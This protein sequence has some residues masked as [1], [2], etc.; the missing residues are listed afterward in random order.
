VATEADGRV[1]IDAGIAVEALGGLSNEIASVLAKEFEKAMGRAGIDKALIKAI[2]Q[3]LSSRANP[4]LR[5]VVRNFSE[6]LVKE[7]GKAGTQMGE[8]LGDKAILAA[9]TRLTKGQVEL[10]R[11]VNQAISIVEKEATKRT[12][13]T[14]QATIKRAEIEAPA[15]LASA[16]AKATEATAKLKTA[17][18]QLRLS[19]DKTE[20]E[21]KRVEQRRISLART[22]STIPVR[23]EEVAGRSAVNSLINERTQQEIA[24]RTAIENA[25]RQRQLDVAS[26]QQDE[27]RRTLRLQRFN[28]LT[29][30]LTQAGLT[31][32]RD[33]RRNH[34]N[35]IITEQVSSDK[36]EERQLRETLSRRQLEVRR[37]EEK[38]A[39]TQ[40]SSTQALLSQRTQTGVLGAA[41]GISP[42]GASLRNIALIGGGALSLRAIFSSA[43]DFLANF[44]RLGALTGA[45]T[46]QLEQLRK[47]AIAL[48]NDLSLPGVSAADATESLTRLVQAGFTVDQAIGAAKG[49]LLLA[50][51]NML[52][53][54]EAA[55]FTGSAINSFRID[56]DKAVRI[57]DIAQRSLVSGGG[58]SF[59]ELSQGIQQAGAVFS[60]FF[61]A[62]RGGQGAFED[63]NIALDILAKNGLRG[64]DAGTSLKTFLLALTGSSTQ[65]Q[66]AI[67]SLGTIIGKTGGEV[68]GLFFDAAGKVLPFI[69]IIKNLRESLKDFSQEAKLDFL[70][71]I[72]GTDAFRAASI[73]IGQTDEQ[74]TG[75]TETIRNA[76]GTSELLGKAV[77][78][79]MRAAFDN[80]NSVIETAGILLI[81]KIDKPLGRVINQF[82]TLTSNLL[83]GQGVYSTIRAALAGMAVALGAILAAKGGVEVLGLLKS[84]LIGMASPAQLAALGVLAIG[85]AIGIGIQKVG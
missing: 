12:R 83:Q 20:R 26:A 28:A 53:F 40:R 76:A 39:R 27:K 15:R 32:I 25:K 8:A 7:F 46:A 42:I 56:A 38:I 16:T 80:F 14:N 1:T 50:R 6:S 60:Q 17:N 82:A 2:S 33:A 47:T 37:F 64:S 22:Q 58:Q 51:N 43:Q 23:R 44:R 72:F 41:R 29:L 52:D 67:A 63:M 3:D 49:T 30:Q 59:T 70:K 65:A 11:Q 71:K 73:F 36:R 45:T 69:D 85:G 55:Q 13:S 5:S 77:N 68:G 61:T 74:L 75:F 54:G 24:A 19:L 35:R 78:Q 18:D 81:E 21:E 79:G 62:I 48:G 4:K 57:V 10:Q 66:K 84:T 31:K 34:N 9:K